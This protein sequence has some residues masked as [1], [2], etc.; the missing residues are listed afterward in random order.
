[1]KVKICTNTKRITVEVD[2][3]I[4]LR[5]LLE[6]NRIDTNSSVSVEGS[7]LSANDLDETLEDLGVGNGDK[8]QITTKSKNA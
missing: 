4:T 8:F 6:D 5:E 1:M 7:Q 2:E 3:D